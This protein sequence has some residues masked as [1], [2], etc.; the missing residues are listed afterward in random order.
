[1]RCAIHLVA[2]EPAGHNSITILIIYSISFQKSGKQVVIGAP[3]TISQELITTFNIKT[4]VR[5]K[6]MISTRSIINELGADDNLY[7]VCARRALISFCVQKVQCE[8][9][10]MLSSSFHE[11]QTANLHL[12][13]I[14]ISLCVQVPRSLGI[15]KDIPY[16]SEVTT[17]TLVARILAD[18]DAYE[19]RN[20]RKTAAEDMYTN[21]K[22]FVD[23]I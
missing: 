14:N 9:V 20:R 7:E 2:V 6:P 3:M 16:T 5:P 19:E 22:T 1:M 4:V 11:P 21:S 15:L 12:K 8:L 18:K 17:A 23:E 10:L 13:L